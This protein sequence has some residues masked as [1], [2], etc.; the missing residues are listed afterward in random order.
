MRVPPYLRSRKWG[1]GREGQRA[2]F[3]LASPAWEDQIAGHHF[4]KIDRCQKA[5]TKIK[6]LSLTEKPIDLDLRAHLW[7]WAKK[8]E[9]L[10][11]AF[12]VL[13]QTS[14]PGGGIMFL[15]AKWAGGQLDTRA[16]AEHYRLP[17][18]KYKSKYKSK[19]HGGRQYKEPLSVKEL[20]TK[21][22]F[23]LQNASITRTLLLCQ[24]M[25]FNSGPRPC[26]T[27]CLVCE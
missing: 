1:L 27:F 17:G 5:M 13:N 9:Y 25:M 8:T 26:H 10:K 16:K 6:M 4:G 14:R 19:Y 12:F 24:N 23:S 11:E 7:F 22:I 2:L 20:F 3:P 15:L 21:I 18:T